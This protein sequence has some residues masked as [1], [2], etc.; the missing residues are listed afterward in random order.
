MFAVIAI[1]AALAERERTGRGQF[2]KSALFE[3]TAFLMTQH[4]AGQAVTGRPPPPM[5]AREGAWGIYDL[6]ITA[7]DEQ[8]F[9][10]LTSDNHWRRFCGEFERGEL[11]EDSKFTSNA[12]RVRERETLRP[13]VAD[14]VGRY[15]IEQLTGI[16]DRIGI[17]FSPVVRPGDLFGDPQLNAQGRMLDVAFPNGARANMPRL[18]IEMGSHDLGLRRQAPRLGEHTAQLLTEIGL[19]SAEIETLC[20]KGIIAAPSPVMSPQH[21]RK[22]KTGERS[23]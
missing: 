21:A 7:D 22:E 23:T 6:F 15:T 13:L 18:P 3:T 5:P 16:F 14:I 1:Q 10:A 8:I 19:A 17:P 12:D 4:M 11:I 9:V 2:V 20:R